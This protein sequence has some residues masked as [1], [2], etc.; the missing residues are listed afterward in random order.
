MLGEAAGGLENVISCELLSWADLAL[1]VQLP[2]LAVNDDYCDCLDGADE[3]M[4][5]ACPNNVFSCANS[6]GIPR[7]I[8]S[9]FVND[10]VCDCCDGS[11]EALGTCR[12]NTCRQELSEISSRIASLLL[13]ERHGETSKQR[14]LEELADK[15]ASTKHMLKIAQATASP[16]L[17]AMQKL[18][19][20]LAEIARK[21]QKEKQSGKKPRTPTSSEVAEGPQRST[22]R[23][24]TDGSDFEDFPANMSCVAAEE[25]PYVCAYLCTD[26]RRYN[27]TCAL[28]VGGA[29]EPWVFFTFSPDALKYERMMAAY[30]K[31]QAGAIEA[32]AIEHVI[33]SEVWTQLDVKWLELR[34]R[35]S[36]IQRKAAEALEALARAEADEQLLKLVDSGQLGPQG[37]YHGLHGQ[38]LNLTQIQ[39]VGTTALREQWRKF[40]YNICFFANATQLELKP[41]VEAGAMCDESGECST[42]Q[43]AASDI[44]YL[45]RPAGFL[46]TRSDPKRYGLQELFFEPSENTLLF[47]GGASC[48]HVARAVA[49]EFVCGELQLNR[50]LEVKMCCYVAE[51]SHPGA[52]NLEQ[53]PRGLRELDTAS[54]ELHVSEVSSWMLRNSRYLQQEG[55]TDWKLLLAT[56]RST[57]KWLNR[58]DQSAIPPLVT[59]E[60]LK[61]SLLSTVLLMKAVVVLLLGAVSDCI[62]LTVLEVGLQAWEK[63]IQLA[64]TVE[65]P[66]HMVPS[67]F[68][69][70]EAADHAVK[71]SADAWRSMDNTTAA[72]YEMPNFLLPTLERFEQQRSARR[73]YSVSTQGSDVMLLFAFLATVHVLLL[74]LMQKIFSAWCSFAR[75]LCRP[76][77]CCKCHRPCQLKTDGS[78]LDEESSQERQEDSALEIGSAGHAR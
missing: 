41:E 65:L 18:K 70:L 33:P 74:Y 55:V 25:C 38:C 71:W 42:L 20:K 34:Q 10:G 57:Q 53:W 32:A 50:V 14:I 4:T 36:R 22:L 35:L 6:G 19:D 24:F 29:D 45:G 72:I 51:V 78:V 26:S 13:H 67:T 31:T 49:V 21:R 63:L 62:P 47:A 46:H 12:S 61:D 44:I 64:G 27:G 58:V 77:C 23:C 69:L 54:K 59:L 48:G 28:D 60:A 43:E 76:C 2:E 11:D 17:E 16:F 39:Y 9:S 52:C 7:L 56:G 68:F 75:G 5:A 40:V 8:D 15:I 1:H 73:S 3:V 30:G 66:L 37:V